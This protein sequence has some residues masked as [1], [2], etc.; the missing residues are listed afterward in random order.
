MQRGNGSFQGYSTLRLGACL[1]ICHFN[2]DDISTAKSEILLKLMR[3]ENVD[4]IALQ[5]THT[6]DDADFHRRDSI[7]RY[8]LIGVLHNKKYGVATYLKSDISS[9]HFLSQGVSGNVF[10][11]VV[12][13]NEI[14]ISNIYKPPIAT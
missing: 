6:V 1:R 3:N 4:I 8:V 9:A 7:A 5:E 10:N 12:E 2:I 14:N 13:V 11:L